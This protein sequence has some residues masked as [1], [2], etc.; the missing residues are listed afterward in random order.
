MQADSA[1]LTMLLEE[2]MWTIELNKDVRIEQFSISSH[3]FEDETHEPD[4][5]RAPICIP[6][7]AVKDILGIVGRLRRLRLLLDIN[8]ELLENIPKGSR[9]Q[10][11]QT[12]AKASN[13]EHL[14]LAIRLPKSV[15]CFGNVNLG[16][17]VFSLWLADRHYSYLKTVELRGW[18]LLQVLLEEFLA[19]HAS[20]L[21]AIHFINC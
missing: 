18:I 2:L 15:R 1:N 16:K 3:L 20:S 17:V 13:L 12:L 14:T 7:Y 9:S 21:R 8:L 11:Q 4:D 6:A 19:R 10:I 5:P